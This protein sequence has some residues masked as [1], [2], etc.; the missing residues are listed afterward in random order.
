MTYLSWSPDLDT[1]IPEIDN[2]HKQRMDFINRQHDARQHADR[3]G[4]W[5]W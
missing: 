5:R 1:G 4:V 2:Q 3:Q